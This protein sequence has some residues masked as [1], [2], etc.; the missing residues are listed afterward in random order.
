MKV[1]LTSSAPLI[2]SWSSQNTAGETKKKTTTAIMFIG[3]SAGNIV[4]PH[5][6]TTGEAP[7]YTR[8]L[9]SKYASIPLPTKHPF[10][11]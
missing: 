8:G 4:G 5:L 9:V 6:Y 10:P 7:K 11:H 3:Q 2:Y 1:L